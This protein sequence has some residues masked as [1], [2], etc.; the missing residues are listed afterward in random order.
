MV[1]DEANGV[2]TVAL[3]TPASNAKYTLGTKSSVTINVK[4]GTVPT[5]TIANAQNVVAP[6][7]ATFTLTADPQPRQDQTLSVR[8]RPTETGT[9]F[10]SPTFGTHNTPKNITSLNF[11][12]ANQHHIPKH[13]TVQTVCLI[14]IIQ[15]ELLI[16]KY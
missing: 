14:A 15:T 7:S 13:L 4:D 12:S 8:V 3:D 5:I 16:L 11:S 10:L 9:N 6:N 2:I 1:M